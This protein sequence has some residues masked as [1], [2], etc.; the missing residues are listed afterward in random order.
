LKSII[1]LVFFFGLVAC[2]PATITD[3]AERLATDIAVALPPM[4]EFG[5]TQPTPPNRSNAQITQ[6][7]LDLSFEM[8]SGRL[9]PVLSRF[10]G[11]ITIS[12]RPGAPASLS[13]DLDQL[14]SRLQSEANINIRRIADGQDAAITIETLPRARMQRAVPNAACFVVPRIS[15]WAQFQSVNRARDLDWTTLQTRERAV[16]FLPSDVSPQEVRDCLH[17]EVAQAI[18][19]LNDLYRLPDSVFNDD[20]F[21][22]VLTGFDMLVLRAYYDNSLRSG[23]SRAEVGAR[24]PAILARLN[25]A[26]Q[27]SAAVGATR[28]PRS[29]INAIENSLGQDASANRRV[30]AARQ[31]LN[32]AQAQGWSDARLAF[33]YFALGRL[34]LSYDAETSINAFLE[35]GTIYDQIA[36]NGIHL[37]H[38][39]MQ[40]AAFALSAGQANQA[41][42]LV[43]SALPAATRAENAGLLATLLMIKAEAL[44]AVDRSS[45]AYAVRLDSLGWGRYGFGSSTEVQARLTEVALLSP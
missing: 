35:A 1:S 31:A 32:I 8:E 43:N 9:I 26:G 21:H 4:R 16:V 23:M 20:N 38:V 25:P 5:T 42:D 39:N 27:F 11:L 34:S 24:L 36:P 15:S 2:A 30:V 7:I 19:P 22:A 37:A 29:W 18:G 3:V 44:E 10:E 45:E 28:T 17:E 6:D 12:I 14:I 41:L 13:A 40:L 33:S